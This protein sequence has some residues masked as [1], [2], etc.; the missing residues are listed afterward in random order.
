MSRLYVVLSEFLLKTIGYITRSKG[1]FQ[2]ARELNVTR[3]GLYTS[4]P[5]KE[6]PWFSTVILLLAM[7]GFQLRNI[8][9]FTR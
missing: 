2:T 6:T 4:L 5:P 1:M 3:E 8:K 7:H 9:T